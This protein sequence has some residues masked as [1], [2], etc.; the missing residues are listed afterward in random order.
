[1]PGQP[2]AN[3]EYKRRNTHPF[4]QSECHIVGAHRYPKESG[5]RHTFEF[6]L[7]AGGV[8]AGPVLPVG[9]DP[10][11]SPPWSNNLTA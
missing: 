1:M 10:L 8:V 5:N 11:N 4:A 9:R 6:G 7:Q 2:P 3:V